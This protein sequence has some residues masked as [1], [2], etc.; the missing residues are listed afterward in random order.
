MLLIKKIETQ[1]DIDELLQIDSFAE[2]RIYMLSQQA[3]KA[4]FVPMNKLHESE[5]KKFFGLFKDR[6][7]TV[8]QGG[9]YVA[10]QTFELTFDGML[11]AEDTPRKLLTTLG[12][13][14]NGFDFNGDM[15][16]VVNAMGGK[17]EFF[18]EDLEPLLKARQKVFF[19]RLQRLL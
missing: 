8:W 19:D 1:S 6:N 9:Y 11:S 3:G 2:E 17:K 4:E 15:S 7:A 16:E 12:I 18:R 13:K 14:V 5:L 10:E